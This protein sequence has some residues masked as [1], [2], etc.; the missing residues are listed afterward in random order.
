MVFANKNAHEM[1]MA[2]NP[3]KVF[4][5]IAAMLRTKR[6]ANKGGEL[7]NK[8]S[9]GSPCANSWATSR[10]RTSSPFTVCTYRVFTSLPS[11]TLSRETTS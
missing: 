1:S 11:L 10:H 2:I 3:Q 8:S 9:R 5:T 6:A 7:A 4:L